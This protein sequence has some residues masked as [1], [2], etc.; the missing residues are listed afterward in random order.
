M[1][2]TKTAP[3]SKDEL[4]AQ[5][6]TEPGNWETRKELTHLLYNEGRTK[7]A[8]DLVW[9]APEIPSIDL[10]LGFAV[11]VLGKGRPSLA[12]RLLNEIQRLN[13]GKAAQNLGLANALLHHGMVMQAA[14]FYGAAIELDPEVVNPD[15]EHFLLW[16]DDREKLWGPFGEE[17]PKLEELPWIKRDA[18]QADALKQSMKGH[19]T[20]ISI[21]GLKRALA[22]E[23]LHEMYVQSEH[24]G[25]EVSP[26][27]AVT[28]PMDRVNP[29]DVLI[30][31]EL[32]AGRPMTAEEV[33]AAEGPVSESMGVGLPQTPQQQAVAPVPLT[34]P[35]APKPKT[36]PP[37][38]PAQP[39]APAAAAV[40]V[41]APVPPPPPAPEAPVAQPAPPA[42]PAATVP[43]APMTVP[44][45]GGQRAKAAAAPSP[46]IPLRQP[47]NTQV[48]PD[49]KI[50]LPKRK[51]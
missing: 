33:R 15:M 22:E 7:E 46:T 40:P 10:E 28:I 30:D 21:P 51:S 4:T 35:D 19:T 1:S 2:D 24:R 29:K 13:H 26:P 34:R 25:D 5:L 42:P 17:L 38:P 44:L 11:K 37:P 36:P 9:E 16:V 45:A 20:P 8:A 18:A 14:R 43:A 27:P 32:G 47:A 49:G 23:P 39:V 3:R 48:L 31:N 50:R 41:A 12:I 6:A